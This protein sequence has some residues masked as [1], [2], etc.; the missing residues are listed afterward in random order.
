MPTPTPPLILIHILTPAL[1]PRRGPGGVAG[2]EVEVE[3]E[4]EV[5]IWVWVGA[6]V[7]ASAGVALHPMGTTGGRTGNKIR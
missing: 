4:V 2:V 7:V 3:V 5:W 6:G 1:H